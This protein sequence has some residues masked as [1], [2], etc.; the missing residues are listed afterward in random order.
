MILTYFTSFLL[1]PTVHK[2]KHKGKTAGFRGG[3]VLCGEVGQSKEGRD[4]WTT[5]GNAREW[6]T[7]QGKNKKK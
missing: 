6:G 2:K 3:L 7:K 5:V 4:P 1:G